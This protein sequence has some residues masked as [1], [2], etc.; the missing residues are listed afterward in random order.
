MIINAYAKALEVI[1]RTIADNAGLDSIDV[2]NKLRQKHAMGSEGKHY[3]V[4]VHNQSGIINTYDNFVWE[5]TLVKQNALTA[6]TEVFIYFFYF[7]KYF[8]YLFN[9]TLKYYF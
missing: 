2:M 8:I 9:N 1:P 6:A 7:Y 3:G 5:P 4:N